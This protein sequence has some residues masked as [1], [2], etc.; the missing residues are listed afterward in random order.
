MQEIQLYC[1]HNIFRVHLEKNQD[2]ER[3]L[4]GTLPPASNRYLF[5]CKYTVKY[6]KTLLPQKLKKKKNTKFYEKLMV[7]KKVSTLFT[8][9]FAL[10]QDGESSPPF[11]FSETE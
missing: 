2:S 1:Y 11:P 10:S 7:I 6:V 5:H 4:S 3:S 9:D 8:I